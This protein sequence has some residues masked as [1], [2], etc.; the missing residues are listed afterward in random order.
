MHNSA[1]TAALAGFHQL[2]HCPRDCSRRSSASVMLEHLC[3]CLLW[4]MPLSLL[5]ASMSCCP[6]RGQHDTL[7]TLE[8]L[9]AAC[10]RFC[11]CSTTAW[12][13][14][15]L[16]NPVDLILRPLVARPQVISYEHGPYAQKCQAKA[17]NNMPV[18]AN[19][20]SPNAC[21]CWVSRT[22]SS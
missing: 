13:C 1:Q 17:G 8:L 10:I 18:H 5:V 7:G 16:R 19:T 12:I 22:C 9:A 15:G 3:S 2:Q 6:C 21:V 20:S 4:Y 11:M 14:E